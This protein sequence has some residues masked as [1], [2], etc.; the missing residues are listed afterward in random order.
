MSIQFNKVT[1]Y[2]RLLALILFLGIIPLI[3]FYIGTQYETAEQAAS[4]T[5]ITP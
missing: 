3:A 5:V 4:G 1:W 2:S